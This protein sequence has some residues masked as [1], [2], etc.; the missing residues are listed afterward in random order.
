MAID[1][2][3]GF[4]KISASSVKTFDSCSKK[5]YYSYVAK[6]DL[7]PKE[8]QHLYLGTFCHAVLESFHKKWMVDKNLELAPLMGECFLEERENDK[9]IGGSQIDEAKTMLQDYLFMVETKGMPN[10]LGVEEPFSFSV[11]NYYLRGF[12]DRIDIEKDGSFHIV[13]YKTSKNEKYLDEFQLLVYSLAL[14][15]KYPEIEKIKGS[16]VL[17]RQKSKPLSYNFN[18]YDIE[19]CEQKLIEYGNRITTEQRWEKN[20][21][22]LCSWCDF[23]VLCFPNRHKKTEDEKD[24]AGNLI[25][26]KKGESWT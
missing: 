19:E 23:E 11:G 4:Y 18:L 17:L 9:K 6:P 7:P 15:V 5:Y 3:T 20:P 25:L 22:K 24:T 14:K 2:K 13:D 21:T 10:V 16:Y 8:W 12:I 1:E 26:T